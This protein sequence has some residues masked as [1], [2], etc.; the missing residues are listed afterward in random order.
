VS[1]AADTGRGRRLSGPLALAATVLVLSLALH[2]RDPHRAGSWGHCP[3]LLM[4]G[5]Y[6]PG[7]GGLRAVAD[8]ARGDVGAAASSNL[9][10]VASAPLLAGWWLTAFVDRWRGVTRCVAEHRQL[11]AALVFVAV[12]VGFAVL[13][14][15]AAGTWLAP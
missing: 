11:G 9:L 6:C 15:T 1:A 4:T 14:N 2:L 7:C 13:R 5:T 8:L 12:A 3:W 10:L